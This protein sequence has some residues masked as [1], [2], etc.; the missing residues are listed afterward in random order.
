MSSRPFLSATTTLALV[1]NRALWRCDC[2]DIVLHNA[3]TNCITIIRRALLQRTIEYGWKDC[4]GIEN[5]SRAHQPL[6]A[7]ESWGHLWLKCS[8]LFAGNIIMWGSWMLL[9]KEK[10]CNRGSA[11]V[12]FVLSFSVICDIHTH[13]GTNMCSFTQ[14]KSW[15]DMSPGSLYGKPPTVCSKLL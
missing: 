14:I 4:D 10:L 11:W 1:G 13:S 6:K 12:H 9:S 3:K 7:T 5:Y 8:R 2:E 15:L